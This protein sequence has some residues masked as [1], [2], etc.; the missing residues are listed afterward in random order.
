MTR[1]R[2]YDDAAERVKLLPDHEGGRQVKLNKGEIKD[3]EVRKVDE[4]G[5]AE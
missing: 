3:K 1:E 2:T 5:E 4:D